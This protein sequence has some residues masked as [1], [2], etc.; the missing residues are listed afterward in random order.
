VSN[1][2][3]VVNADD[4]G[5]TLGVCKAVI[6]AHREGIVT[7]TSILA[8]GRPF[9]QAAA[10]LQDTPTLGVGAHLALVGEDPPLLSAREVPTLVDRSG[11][12]PLSWRMAVRRLAMGRVDPADV[13]RELSA[14]LDRIIGIGLPV[15]HIDTHQHLH[16]WPTVGRVVVELAHE[17]H[18][19]VV[20]RPRSRRL[21]V[22][23]GINL[24][25]YALGRRFEATGLVT[26]DGF[27]G[28]DQAGHLDLPKL[29][30]SLE[31]MR[32]RD[33]RT[34]EVNTHPGEPG[35]PELARFAWGYDW[36]GE[37]ALLCAR[38]TRTAIERI[39]YRL[40]NFADLAVEVPR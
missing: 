20:R 30:R 32:R 37:L 6:R 3:L 36:G 14:Q 12:F 9:E 28:L 23:T 38:D 21:G 39:G 7:S 18:I 31:V 27:A 24:L 40:G 4:F 19:N 29:A 13:R 26:T 22:G 35:D 1:R 25:S 16:L 11:R 10:F 17:R 8:V 34:V 15:T 33:K 2:L 5:L